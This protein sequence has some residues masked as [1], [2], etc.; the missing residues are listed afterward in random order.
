MAGNRDRFWVT[1]RNMNEYYVYALYDEKGWPFYVGKGKGYRINN[2]LKPALLK[3]SCYKNHKIKKL[4]TIQGYVRRDILAYCESEEVSLLLERDLIA[5]YGIYTE[6]GLLTNHSKSHW[7]LPNKAFEKRA[8]SQKIKRQTSVSDVEIKEAY[9][10]WKFEL[11]SIRSLAGELNISEA[12][13]GKIFEGKKRKDL[14]LTNCYPRRQSLRCGYTTTMLKKL[15]EDRLINGLS[16][17]KLMSKYDLPKTTVA[18]ILK[19]EGV[20]SFLREFSDQLS[21]GTGSANGS[22]GD[23]ST[24]NSENT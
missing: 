24:A 17:T 12:Y 3:E 8:V 6:G 14:N 1:P 2:H 11:V 13:L 18:R 7:D 16:Y 22:S 9:S 4:L 5:A 21:N 20:Y 10:K 23:S 19:M 15:V